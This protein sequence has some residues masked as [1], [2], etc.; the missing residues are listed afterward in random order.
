ME[1]NSQ[2]PQ[3][4][5]ATQNPSSV[6]TTSQLGEGIG[7]V[8]SP[9][10]TQDKSLE[11]FSQT[12]AKVFDK[13]S[14]TVPASNDAENVSPAGPQLGGENVLKENKA[15]TL[16][17]AERKGKGL[18]GNPQSPSAIATKQASTAAGKNE[19]GTLG[20][21]RN[22]SDRQ[23]PEQPIGTSPKVVVQP[24]ENLTEI[25][26]QHYPN[27][28]RSGIQAILKSNPYIENRDRIYP[29]Q[30]LV[31]PE[32]ETNSNPMRESGKKTE[33]KFAVQICTLFNSSRAFAETYINELK[34][35]GYSAYS[36]ETKTKKDKIIYKIFIGNYVSKEEAETA[37]RDF[38]KN[39]GQLDII[40]KPEIT[41][42]PESKKRG[43]IRGLKK[44]EKKT[45][46]NLF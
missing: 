21:Q 11:A 40:I 13:E 43:E 3:P 4:Y 38:Q 24:G 14:P 33:T 31:L 44:K 23:L 46:A 18:E 16:A 30:V 26:L 20:T 45:R 7:S 29:G 35:K 25:A 10:T 22:H 1:K 6:D 42:A 12:P 28:K 41:Q 39:G 37:A 9:T 8:Y 5:S 17:D 2:A 27:K 32:I 34:Q 19:A 15:L 36:A